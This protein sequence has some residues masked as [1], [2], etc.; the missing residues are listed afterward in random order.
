MQVQCFRGPIL[1][2]V[3]A[4]S[5]VTAPQVAVAQRSESLELGAQVPVSGFSELDSTDAGVGGHATWYPWTWVGADAELN[6]YPRT[7]PDDLR[8]ISTHRFEGLFGVTVGPRRG[9]WRP[10]ARIR[11][12]FLQV[13]SASRL[14]PCLAIFPPFTSCGLAGGET[15][16]A[17]EFGTGVE[18]YTPGRSFVR[19][20]LGDRMLRFPGPAIDHNRLVHQGDYFTHDFRVAFGGGW[21]F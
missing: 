14:V 7:I 11:P 10:I 12:G 16:F 13:G 8:A 4:V 9:A 1:S 3:V 19:V 20:D 17:L 21:R 18:I 2:V 6:F 5:V 15:L